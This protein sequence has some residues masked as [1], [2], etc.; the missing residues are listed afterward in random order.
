[1]FFKLFLRERNIDMRKTNQLPPAYLIL[2]MC[3]DLDQTSNPLVYV[4]TVNQLSHI[5]QADFWGLD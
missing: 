3:P 2:G 4:M 1:M 5:G